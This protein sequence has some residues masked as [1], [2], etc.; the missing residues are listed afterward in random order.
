MKSFSKNELIGIG[1]ILL[2]ISLASLYNFRISIRRGRDAQ[3]M[4]DLGSVTNALVRY[5]D[6]F[7]FYPAS[8]DGKVAAC[9]PVTIEGES[10]IFSP[11]EWG[12]D[13]LRDLFDESYP[14][15][16]E[17][18]PADPKA[19]LGF[20]YTYLSNGNRFQVLASLEGEDEEEYQEAIVKRQIACGVKICNVGKASG[21]TPLEK[22]IE[23]YE[24]ELLEKKNEK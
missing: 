18:L 23:E 19:E 4:A 15:Y 12:K 7:G 16:L 24:N 2:A 21:S 6:D 8:V 5:G 1:I 10:F 22:S 20:S 11:C 13:S 17:K 3:R 14:A 9:E